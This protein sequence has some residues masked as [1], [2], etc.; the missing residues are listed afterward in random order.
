MIST[1]M[2]AAYRAGR[3][4]QQPTWR[5]PLTRKLI[6][7]ILCAVWASPKTPS[8]CWTRKWGGMECL[9]WYTPA[10][11]GK[12][13]SPFLIGTVDS[14]VQ[15][16]LRNGPTLPADEGELERWCVEQSCFR[17]AEMRAGYWRVRFR[18]RARNRT[19]RAIGRMGSFSGCRVGVYQ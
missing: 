5:S 18:M 16:W 2:G 1:P 3:M 12:K 8:S 9:S 15:S 6:S 11:A 7:R 17:T 19:W 14:Y 13:L 10:I 4:R